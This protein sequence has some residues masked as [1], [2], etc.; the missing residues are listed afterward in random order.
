MGPAG[1]RGFEGATSGRKTAITPIRRGIAHAVTRTACGRLDLEPEIVPSYVGRPSSPHTSKVPLGVSSKR[2]AS[3][4]CKA[5]SPEPG[6]RLSASLRTRPT[7][8][9]SVLLISFRVG[10]M[11]ASGHVGKQSTGAKGASRQGASRAL[12]LPGISVSPFP[13]RA[14]LKPKISP[15]QRRMRQFESVSTRFFRPRVPKPKL[16]ARPMASNPG[17][18]IYTCLAR[19]VVSYDSTSTVLSS[20]VDAFRLQ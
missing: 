12:D 19:Q 11:W 20:S 18:Q 2:E 10:T 15:K 8:G 4:I 13:G 14:K 3:T 17:S 7:P 6:T 1:R 16:N 5:R 9:G